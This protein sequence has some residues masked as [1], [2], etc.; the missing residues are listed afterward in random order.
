VDAIAAVA[1]GPI[2]L[3][4]IPLLVLSEIFR[5]IDLFVGVCTIGNDPTWDDGGPDNRHR[6]YWRSYNTGKLSETT[7]TRADLLRQLLPQLA[8][9]P[10]CAVDDRFMHVKG[11]LRSYKIHLGSGN[12]MMS[13]GDTYLCI[14]P[15]PRSRDPFAGVPLPFEGDQALAVIL[16]KAML[17]ANDAKITDPTITRQ[18]RGS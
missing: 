9:G 15:D 16:S 3:A 10:R 1:D 7:C 17:L 13:P 6:T 18:I 11:I 4:D 2:P 14:V 12:V 8:I 5:D